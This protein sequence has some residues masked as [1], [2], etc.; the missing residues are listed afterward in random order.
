[1]ALATALITV[2]AGGTGGVLVVGGKA[3]IFA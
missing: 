2:A 3:G 1:M